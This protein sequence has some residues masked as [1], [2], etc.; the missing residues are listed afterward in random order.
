MALDIQK[1]KRK[2]LVVALDGVRFVAVIHHAFRNM[3][4][5]YVA[6]VLEK[7]QIL[8]DLKN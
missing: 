1:E 8:W 2:N 5:I 3:T 7:L 6:S 4:Y